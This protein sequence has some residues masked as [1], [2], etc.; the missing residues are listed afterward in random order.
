MEAAALLNQSVLVLNRNWIAVHVCNA[1]RA[2]ILLYQDLARVVTEDY[3]TLD[4]HNWRDVSRFASDAPVIRTPSYQLR[5]PQVRRRRH[6][7]ARDAGMARR[8]R[9]GF[10]RC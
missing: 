3:E 8:S 7:A 4:F 5:I 2:L 9:R 6:I 1:R 10:G